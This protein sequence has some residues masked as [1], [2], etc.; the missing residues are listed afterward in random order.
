MDSEEAKPVSSEEDKESLNSAKALANSA[1]SAVAQ[2]P[3]TAD[4]DEIEY[5]DFLRDLRNSQSESEELLPCA[6]EAFLESS[7]VERT[8]PE[9]RC[10]GKGATQWMEYAVRM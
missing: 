6:N 3:V 5:E 10:T 2:S 8:S 9:K 4:S 7:S 1:R